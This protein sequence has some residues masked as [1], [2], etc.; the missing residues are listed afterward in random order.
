MMEGEFWLEG[1]GIRI[2]RHRCKSSKD[3]VEAESSK[4]LLHE[5]KM[6]RLKVILA[7]Q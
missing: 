3:T 4:L 1:W 7:D 6:F 2:I 5:I